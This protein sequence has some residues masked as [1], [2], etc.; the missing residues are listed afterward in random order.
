MYF[1]GLN[2]KYI[3][4]YHDIIKHVIWLGINIELNMVFIFT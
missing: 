2:Y 1:F 3:K 4:I